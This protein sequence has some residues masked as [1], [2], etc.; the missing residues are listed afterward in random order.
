[1]GP[2]S[3]PIW[4]PKDFAQKKANGEQWRHLT[5]MWLETLII[6]EQTTYDEDKFFGVK[7]GPTPRNPFYVRILNNNRPLS[8]LE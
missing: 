2:E 1:M 7:V 4:T 5:Y 6:D 3:I 8:V